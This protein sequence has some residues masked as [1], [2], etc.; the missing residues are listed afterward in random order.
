M[1]PLAKCIGT[2]RIMNLWIRLLHQ[3]IRFLLRLLCIRPVKFIKLNVHDYYMSYVPIGWSFET[4]VVLNIL[5]FSVV[6]IV[7]LL[8]TA[9]VARVRPISAI[10]FD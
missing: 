1:T 6:T 8:P 4:V 9:I 7:L 3:R 2:G 5:T 10:R